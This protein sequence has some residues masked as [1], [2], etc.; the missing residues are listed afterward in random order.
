MR[1]SGSYPVPRI[2]EAR[3]CSYD[4]PRAGKR[5]FVPHSCVA[6]PRPPDRASERTVATISKGRRPKICLRAECSDIRLGQLL[7]KTECSGHSARRQSFRPS[8]FRSWRSW[9]LRRSI[10][11]ARW[12]DTRVRRDLTKRFFPSSGAIVRS[13]AWPRPILGTGIPVPR[14]HQLFLATNAIDARVP[15]DA[16]V[17]TITTRQQ[18]LRK[19]K[20]L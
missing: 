12:S 8:S 20:S 17:S 5:L 14:I 19:K 7:S 15:V 2:G 3:L 9:S 13:K 10:R 6:P 11:R 1:G 4:H 16:V 18:Q